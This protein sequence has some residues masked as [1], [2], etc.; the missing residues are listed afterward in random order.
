MGEP[1]GAEVPPNER[2]LEMYVGSLLRFGDEELW[3][4]C[5][6]PLPPVRRAGRVCCLCL[7][8]LW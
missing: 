4:V 3:E 1:S 2:G 6:T 5:K 7:S 8:D